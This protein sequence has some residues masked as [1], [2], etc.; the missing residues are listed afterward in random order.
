RHARRVNRRG[1][2]DERSRSETSDGMEEYQRVTGIIVASLMICIGCS[3]LAICTCCG[4]FCLNGVPKR[5]H[6]TLEAF[7]EEL[8]RKEYLPRLNDETPGSDET[9]KSELPELE[10]LEQVKDARILHAV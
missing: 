5:Y 4:Y 6:A 2:V 1:A 7:V 3:C 9:E 10:D 8:Q